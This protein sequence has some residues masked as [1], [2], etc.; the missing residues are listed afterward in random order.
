VGSF[1]KIYPFKMTKGK[2]YTIDLES[3]AFDA[4]LGLENSKGTQLAEDDDSGGGLNSRI[5]IRAP[6]DGTYRIIATSPGTGLG[7]FTLKVRQ[8]Q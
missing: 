8:D 3:K 5:T 7:A 6:E 2:D 4:Y 1:A